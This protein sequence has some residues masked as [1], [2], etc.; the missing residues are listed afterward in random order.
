[1]PKFPI[2]FNNQKNVVINAFISTEAAV[3]KALVQCPSASWGKEK[4]GVF[5]YFSK[6]RFTEFLI[7]N[8]A[9]F[10][11]GKAFAHREISER[12]TFQGYF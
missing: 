5:L 9:A 2:V 7:F 12:A 11:L 4:L 1:V 3:Q 8:H 6:Y 10:I